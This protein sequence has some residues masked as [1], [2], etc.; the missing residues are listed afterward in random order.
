MLVFK[1]LKRKIESLIKGNKSLDTK[2]LNF[3]QIYQINS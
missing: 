1:V 2:T 3:E